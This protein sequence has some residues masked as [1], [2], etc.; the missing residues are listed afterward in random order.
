MFD[1]GVVLDGAQCRRSFGVWHG[2]IVEFA[3]SLHSMNVDLHAFACLAA[4]TLVTGTALDHQ[5]AVSWSK[6][7]HGWKL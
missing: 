3:Q 1:N 6:V 5:G 4:L 2:A 7:F